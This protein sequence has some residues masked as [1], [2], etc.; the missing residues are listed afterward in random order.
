MLSLLEHYLAPDEILPAE[1]ETKEILEE[2]KTGDAPEPVLFVSHDCSTEGCKKKRTKECVLGMCFQCC[3][4][5]KASCNAHFRQRKKREEEEKFLEQGMLSQSKT[6]TSFYHYE[7][8]F[9]KCD[10]TVVIWCLKDFLRKKE[11]SG[12]IMAQYKREQRTRDLISRRHNLNSST[13]VLPSASTTKS[14]A[15]AVSADSAEDEDQQC[16]G[17]WNERSRSRPKSVQQA[18]S[19]PTPSTSAKRARTTTPT[20]SYKQEILL[21]KNVANNA[22]TKHAARKFRK[23]MTRWGKEFGF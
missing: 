19:S 10:Q 18:L 1:E 16:S 3:F 21:G 11:W 23:V 5:R 4:D 17:Q 9:M 6:K 12:D 20:E 15:A 8:K 2:L 7:E 14:G 22:H 13:S